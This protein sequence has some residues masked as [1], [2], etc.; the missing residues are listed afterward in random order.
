MSK[1]IT[2]EQDNCV[3][4]TFPWKLVVGVIV[5]N[6]EKESSLK[7]LDTTKSQ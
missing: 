7:Y 3:K 5:S 2:N 6:A 4:A 1:W